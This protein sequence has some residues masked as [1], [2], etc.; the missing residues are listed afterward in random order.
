MCP[1]ALPGT[2][3]IS[4]SNAAGGT[5]C[6][7]ASSFCGASSLACG[8]GL[9]GAGA[10]AV[11]AGCSPMG[12][13][14]QPAMIAA[15]A[16]SAAHRLPLRDSARRAAQ[17]SCRADRVSRVM[18]NRFPILYWCFSLLA[19][20]LA[21]CADQ[22]PLERHEF[23]R[24]C[25]GVQTRAVLY[26]SDAG[27][28]EKAAA[29]AFDEIGRLE[30]IMSD[31][32]PTSELSQLC[33]RAGGAPVSVSKDL[34][35]ILDVSLRVARASD[36]AFDPTVGPLVLLWRTARRNK[37]LPPEDA[38]A[39]ARPLVDWRLVSLNPGRR[40]VQLAKPGMKLD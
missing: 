17:A 11:A 27:R 7:N 26:T 38:L 25:M 12:R 24:V 33:E 2:G 6:L 40:E 15:A 8:A 14:S 35:D 1:P 30:Q 20:A 37:T 39:A 5:F 10:G 32:R 34:Y 29:A 18:S 22:R 4:N 9:H 3:S 28:A 19:A 21:G 16:P 31:Y 23:T 13:T 36:G